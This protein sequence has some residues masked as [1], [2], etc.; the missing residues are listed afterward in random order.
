MSGAC[1]A[2]IEQPPLFG[3]RAVLLSLPMRPNASFEPGQQHVVKLQSLR[4]MQR[5]NLHRISPLGFTGHGAKCGVVTVS[6]HAAS[7][8]RRPQRG[9]PGMGDVPPDVEHGGRRDRV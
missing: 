4:P 7:L 3:D 8:L 6:R 5:H 1:D 9:R 2:D